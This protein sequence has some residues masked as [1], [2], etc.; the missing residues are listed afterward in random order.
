MT[1]TITRGDR[2]RWIVPVAV[3]A[4]AALLVVLVVLQQ[5]RGAETEAAGPDRGGPLIDQERRDPDDRLAVGPVDA[6]VGLVVF[7]DYQCPYC[8]RWSAETLPIMLE[9]AAAGDLRIEWRDVNVF[10]PASER[11]ARGAYAAAKQDRLWDYH[12]ALFPDGRTRSEAEL[13]DD[14]LIDLARDLGLDVDRFR[15][16][17]AAEETASE[18]ER[19][20]RQG[21][22]ARAHATPT[23]VLD[24][25]PIVGAQ[26]TATFVDALDA[27]LDREAS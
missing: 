9:R 7:S 5:A 21:L 27:A 11:A 3:G 22:E 1:N 8:A 2:R 4:V 16:D 19:N 25:D 12:D 20:E 24:G 6:P 13:R 10:G 17:L 23:F 15:A 14:G 26:P 18:I